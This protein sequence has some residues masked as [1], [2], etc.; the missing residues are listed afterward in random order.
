MRGVY[1]MIAG[2]VGLTIVL[3]V[4]FSFFEDA[5]AD[6]KKS[7]VGSTKALPTRPADAFYLFPKDDPAFRAK[8]G[9]A[10]KP[11]A[12]E[13]W[14]KTCDGL[15]ASEE[16]EYSAV[17]EAKAVQLWRVMPLLIILATLA[18]LF[19]TGVMLAS[20]NN[21]LVDWVVEAGLLVGLAL[22]LSG[23]VIDFEGD[24]F[25]ELAKTDKFR[26]VNPLKGLIELSYAAAI[27]VGLGA[28]AFMR[29]RA[30]VN[31]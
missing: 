11:E 29:M 4:L 14:G 26:G 31:F 9:S 1:M 10:T 13:D 8:P 19:G 17:R 16:F 20:A 5:I 2:A 30:R 3:T 27:L 6:P 24:L 23:L 12:C 7:N 22:V 21:S 28:N 18:G 15:Q 25:T